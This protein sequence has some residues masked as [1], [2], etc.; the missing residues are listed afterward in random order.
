MYLILAIVMLREGWRL[1]NAHVHFHS[2]A[3]EHSLVSEK[4]ATITPKT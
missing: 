2:L 1:Y 3:Q 4:M